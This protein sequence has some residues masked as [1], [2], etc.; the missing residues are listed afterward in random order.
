MRLDQ[1]AA[2]RGASASS[3][4]ARARRSASTSRPTLVRGAPPASTAPPATCSTNAVAWNRDGRALEVSVADG[5]RSCATT[6]PGLRTPTSTRLR[7]L[8]SCADSARQRPARASGS[9][10]SARS[11]R[12]TAAAWAPRAPAAAALV[13]RL[14]GD[15]FGPGRALR[16]FLAFVSLLSHSRTAFAERRP[17]VASEEGSRRCGSGRFFAGGPALALVFSCVQAARGERVR[18]GESA[19][20]DAE[21]ASP[22]SAGASTT[23]TDATTDGRTSSDD[24]PGGRCSSSTTECMREEG[25][26]L[27]D[28]DFSGEPA[29]RL[30]D[31]DRRGGGGST[32]TIPTFRAGAERSA[33]NRSC[34]RDLRQQYRPRGPARPGA[35]R[36]SSSSR[37]AC[38]STGSTCPTRTSPTELPAGVAPRAAR[39]SSRRHRSRR[40]R[41][42]PGG[43][44]GLR[45]DVFEEAGGRF[46]AG[47]RPAPTTGTRTSEPPGARRS[48]SRPAVAARRGRR[49]PRARL[50]GGDE[51]TAAADAP[52]VRDR[53]GR[54]ARPR[55]EDG[56]VR[57]D[58]RLCKHDAR[59]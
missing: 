22:E 20:G 27:P 28:P 6:A 14:P 50:P 34:S 36:R 2:G 53:G 43:A 41:G 47:R 3:G 38:A 29:R 11:P 1:V 9:R 54:P 5:T 8:L 49:V 32:A 35:G 44:G 40:P 51:T 55:T 26:D 31:P 12:P 23:E 52:A 19:P 21:V 58:A 39:S 46:S 13:S 48:S 30:Q 37:S 42:L 7:P 10:S 33:A 59:S 24:P 18:I 25:I 57:R 45:R 56:L 4:A 17:R 16:H 15:P